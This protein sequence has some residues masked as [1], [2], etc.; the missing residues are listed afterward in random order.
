[1]KEMI[2]VISSI[3]KLIIDINNDIESENYDKLVQ[4][5][6]KGNELYTTYSWW[7]LKPEI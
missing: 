2:S 3:D 5:N 1:M 7:L 6:N 4:Y